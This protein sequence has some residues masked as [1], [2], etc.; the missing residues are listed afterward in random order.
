ME[1]AVRQEIDGMKARLVKLENAFPAGDTDGHKRYHE[2]MIEDI[3]DRKRLMALLKEKSLGA[4][5]WIFIVFISGLIFHGVH[6]AAYNWLHDA[7]TD[8]LKK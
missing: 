5:L 4:V 8:N 6:D 7:P 1:Q 3:N 2:L